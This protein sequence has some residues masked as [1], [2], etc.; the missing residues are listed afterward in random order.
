M[1][2]FR[3]PIQICTPGFMTTV[4]LRYSYCLKWRFLISLPLRF[5]FAPLWALALGFGFIRHDNSF[6]VKVGR[7]GDLLRQIANSTLATSHLP[8]HPER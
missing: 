8:C 5:P 6:M 1:L 3:V 4:I 2:S 7:I